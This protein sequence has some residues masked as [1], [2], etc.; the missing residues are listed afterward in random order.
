MLRR[1]FRAIVADYAKTVRAEGEAATISQANIKDKVKK[2]FI[3]MYQVTGVAFAKM[4]AELIK[5][6]HRN[7]HT[8][9]NPEDLESEWI[10][11]MREFVEKRCGEKITAVTRHM[12][13]DIIRV[14]RASFEAG[15]DQGWGADKVAREIMQ[16]QGQIDQ[17]RALRIARTE[18]VGAS[19]EGSM[20]GAKDFRPDSMKKWVV[21]MDGNTRDDHAAMQGEP[22][23]PL[24]QKFLVGGDEMD[25][26]GD[27]SGSAGNVIQCRCG[28]TY[29]PETSFIDSLIS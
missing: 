8:K 18:I 6:A 7:L 29:E 20:K 4:Q 19:N 1:E 10:L 27:P 22:A 26:P 2:S 12:Y 25:Y 11:H 14:T 5:Q 17:F 15:A 21:T 9:A 23:I 3:D 16:R 13:E 24:D 28:V